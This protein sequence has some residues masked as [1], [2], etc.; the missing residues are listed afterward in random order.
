M[1]IDKFLTSYLLEDIPDKNHRHGFMCAKARICILE[2]GYHLPLKE[3]S[4]VRLKEEIVKL[5][6]ANHYP[7]ALYLADQPPNEKAIPNIWYDIYLEELDK[8]GEVLK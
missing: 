8:R 5:E 2:N 3:L 4:I 6:N 7:V 1:N